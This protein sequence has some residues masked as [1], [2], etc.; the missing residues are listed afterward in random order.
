MHDQRMR[1]RPLLDL[2]YSAQ[3]HRVPGMRPEAIHRLGRKRHEFAVAQS[4]HG[5]VELDMCGANNG[6][7]TG[8]LYRR[9]VA[10]IR[11][12]AFPSRSGSDALRRPA[13]SAG[14]AS[15]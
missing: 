15:K 14:R 4:L 10:P 8:E 3:R 12:I 11:E 6:D 5:S 13:N 9:R 2:E 1:R 7:H